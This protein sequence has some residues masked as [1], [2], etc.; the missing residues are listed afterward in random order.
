[1]KFIISSLC[2][3]VFF[4]GCN[5]SGKHRVAKKFFDYDAVDYYFN[6]FDP[7]KMLDLID[8]RRRSESDSFAFGIMM[9]NIPRGIADSSFIGQ[10]ER[11]G[12]KKFFLPTSLFTSLDSIF[13][14]KPSII[15]EATTC[16]SLYRRV[17]VFRKKGRITGI[18]KV[19]TSCMTSQ[20]HGTT[21]NT[22]SFGQDGDYYK[23]EKLL[24]RYR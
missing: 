19:C 12:Y 16:E 23:L 7:N 11:I 22:Y 15:A 17:F 6:D 18:A 9:K 3:L 13:S 2:F 20:I 4:I 10:V 5:T 14:N 24:Q 8:N 21:V 1:M